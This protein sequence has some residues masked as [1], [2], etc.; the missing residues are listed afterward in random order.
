MVFG[1]PPWF[2]SVKQMS[3]FLLLHVSV[4]DRELAQAMARELVERRLAAS[5]HV[6]GPAETVYWWQNE[7]RHGNEWSCRFRTHELLKDRVVDVIE[8]MHPFDVPE[9]F[10]QEIHPATPE[11]EA[12]LM[13]YAAGS[14]P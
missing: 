10:S 11:Y 7:I 6:T 5:V 4:P 8:A 13:Q 12:W 1:F 3:P 2:E 9:I 14:G